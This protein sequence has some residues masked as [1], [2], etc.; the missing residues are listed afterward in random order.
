MK[1]FL[2]YLLL[3]S[4]FVFFVSACSDDDNSIDIPEPEENLTNQLRADAG[5]G[6]VT[7]EWKM[8]PGA[9]TYNIY[10]MEDDGSVEQPTSADLK[11]NGTKI[12][13]V[14]EDIISAPYT[15]TGL[16][17]GKMYWFAL[18]AKAFGEI[19][20][21]LTKAIY[22]IPLADPPLPAPENVRANAGDEEATVTWD[23]VTGAAGY[24]VYYF[25]SFEMYGESPKITGNSYTFTRLKNGQDYIFWM[26]AL[27]GDDNTR[28]GDSSTSFVYPATPSISPPPAAPTNP[29]ITDQNNG[30][31]I[32]DWDTVTGAT[33]Y[34]IYIARAKGVTQ[35]TGQ[36]TIIGTPDAAPKQAAETNL[37][38]GT[39]YI[40]VTALNANGE[41]ADSREVSITIT[42]NP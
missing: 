21:D 35:L 24:K 12:D 39:Y 16:E 38:N 14:T 26:E 29:A 36:A 28:T 5:N 31:I 23:L 22:S 20:S 15:V 2:S 8:L 1:K 17:N 19:E 30:D 27:D 13:G 6:E 25:T 34:R 37:T 42:D 9:D 18:S 11:N 7:L 4:V 3:M 10:Y 40:V 33:S 41:S 32:V